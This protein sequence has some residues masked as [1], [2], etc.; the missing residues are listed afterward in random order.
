M[1][2]LIEIDWL[3]LLEATDRLSGQ[4]LRRS[5]ERFL[6]PL[7]RQVT[8]AWARYFR[9][10]G[11]WWIEEHLPTLRLLVEAA[12]PLPGRGEQVIRALDEYDDGGR[13]LEVTLQAAGRAMETAASR[14]I[15]QL[16]AQISFTLANPRAVAY[17]DRVGANLVAGLNRTS[18]DQLRTVLA[19]GIDAG[20]SYGRLA[21]AIRRKFD[22]FSRSRAL[23]ITRTELGNAYTE[24]TAIIGRDLQ[25]QGLRMEKRWIALADDRVEPECSANAAQQW[26]PMNATFSG[27]TAQPLQHPLCRCSIILRMSP[28]R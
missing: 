9:R 26:I 11:A 4:S 8:S 7:R 13:A 18:R 24:G 21:T 27:G 3:P 22:D 17:M 28:K 5:Q 1:I 23:M 14:A 20:W 15:A 2:L 19:Q 16:G 25:A 6:A 10:Q 12:V